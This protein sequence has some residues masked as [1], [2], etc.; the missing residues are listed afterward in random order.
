MPSSTWRSSPG[1]WRLWK[2]TT[3]G[4]LN[5]V[6]RPPDP[7]ALRGELLRRMRRLAKRFDVGP[8]N[9][10]FFVACG[11]ATTKAHTLTLPPSWENARTLRT[12]QEEYDRQECGDLRAQ[13]RRHAQEG[14]RLREEGRFRKAVKL[15]K[16][17]RGE[18][19]S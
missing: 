8:A 2:T 15:F 1:A 10:R 5:R 6:S 3:A 18:D 9:W 7:A 4:P 13:A 17:A 12:Y 19:P 11:K 14:S 16:Q